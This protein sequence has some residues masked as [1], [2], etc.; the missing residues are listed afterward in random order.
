MKQ[1]FVLTACAIAFAALVTG[2]AGETAGPSETGSVNVNL[3]VGNTDVTSVAFE[4]ECDS[5]ISLNGNFNVVDDRDPPVWATIMDLPVGIC[6]VT[7]IAQDS[8]G[9]TLCTA[10]ENVEVLEN[11]TV[12]V[13]LVLACTIDAEEALGNI[14]ID[15]TF[16]II[17][18]NLCPRLHFLNAVPIN[19]PT[20]GSEVTVLV[21][22][23]D[24]DPLTTA[25]T[26]T[27]GSFFDPAAQLTTYTCDGAAGAQTISVTVTDGNAAC[28]KSKSFEVVCPGVDPCEGVECP[29][30]GNECTVGICTNQSAP[31]CEE[32]NVANGTACNAGGGGELAVNGDFEQGAGLPGWTLFCDQPGA[33]CEATTAEAAAGLWSG[34]VAVQG[35]PADSLIKN[36]NIG[37]GTVQ[38]NSSCDVSLDL[39]GSATDGGVVFVEFFS[40][41]S[42]G[43][44][45]SSVILLGPPTFPTDT[46]TTYSFTT[47]TGPDVSGGV[48]LQLKASCGA[49]A[50]C[51]V[52]AYFD[53]VSVNC[54]GS[55]GEAGTCQ[56]GVCEPDDLCEGV[57]CNDN[58]ECTIDTCDAGNCSNTPDTGA[59]CDGG[60]GTC[61]VQ[62]VCQPNDLCIGVDC[63]DNNECTI[64]VCDPADGSCSNTPDSGASC[65]GGAGTCD[66]QGVCQAN[67]SCEY[68]QD[69]ESLTP[70]DPPQAQPTDLATD[71]WVVGANVF[72]SDGTTF[73]YDYFAFPAPNGGPAFSAVAAGEGGATQGAQQLSIYNDYNNADHGVGRIIEAIVFRE[74]TIA[75]SDVGTTLS[76]TFDAKAG[77]IEGSTTAL[78][79]VKTLNPAASFATTNF[80]TQDTTNLPATWSTF[81]LSLPID[82]SLVGQI[83]QIGA[84]SRATNFEGSGIFYDNMSVCS[85]PAP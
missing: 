48:T 41:L 43:G 64:D 38:P 44:T 42:G 77:N 9:A 31:D 13:D 8:A 72:E 15:A 63:N 19:V 16:E 10:S 39:K 3:I 46:W 12:K 5:G 22:D 83:L 68:T 78:A 35:G 23:G 26:A 59:S 21:S 28:D 84:Q 51:A 55:G 66:A 79:F 67:A 6:T 29:D 45:S 2:C 69:F 53:N 61:D 4:V 62:G 20:S 65:D 57:D 37:I 71:G 27:G 49:V 75:A 47:P 54:G 18:G 56:E 60:A 36:A 33:S 1:V 82:A 24:N 50:S 85:A 40:E 34:N 52:D 58:N 11:Q 17:E 80:I 76:F 81:T 70:G 74:R 14:D 73:A 7:L 25:L 30:T 32:T